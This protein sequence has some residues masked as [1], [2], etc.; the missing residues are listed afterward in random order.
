MGTSTR[1]CFVFSCGN[2]YGR[3]T[4]CVVGL[5]ILHCDTT[6]TFT[7]LAVNL[8][9]CNLHGLLHVLDRGDLSVPHDSPLLHSFL[10]RLDSLLT[11]CCAV[12]VR[13]ARVHAVLI[14]LVRVSLRV[15]EGG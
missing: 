9:L 13:A 8:G 14:Q 11:G 15:G 7:I 12:G 5:S 6:D 4:T 2:G 3:S 10:Q 1:L